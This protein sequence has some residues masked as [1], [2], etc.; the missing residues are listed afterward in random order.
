[1]TL[2]TLGSSLSADSDIKA[3]LLKNDAFVYAHLVKIEKA[4]K[5]ITGDNSRK[6]SDYAY[7]TD[8]GFDIDFDDGSTDGSGAA[9]GSR[10]F[11]ANKLIST[12]SISETIEARASSISIQLSAAAL[13]TETNIDFTTTSSSIITDVD[14]VDAGFA[15]GDKIQL[16]VTGAGNATTHSGNY[17]T[18][19]SFTNNNKTAVID[20][21]LLASASDLTAI[22]TEREGKI[23]FSS[24]EVIGLLNPKENNTTYAGYIN[25]DVKIYKAHIQPDTGIIIGSPYLLFKGIIA[26][27]KIVENPLKSSV[28][29]WVINSHWG[30]FVNVNGRL[31]SD[32]HHRA[33][34]GSGIPDISAL[35]RK[36]YADDLGFLHSEQAINLVSIYQ[37]KETKTRLEKKK[38]FF[39]L[40]KKY[41]Q[42]EYEVEVDREVDLRFNLD[43]KHLPVVYGV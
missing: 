29:T 14:L 13:N 16:T 42:V 26:S 23:T 33:L 4:V 43:A 32:Q 36:E 12:G 18:I 21:T 40:I 35:D 30:D 34:D 38:K 27:S 20:T 7:I 3:S 6:A 10:T 15:E 8:S 37:A 9:N 19:K 39:G 17:Y 28:I 5:T 1:M 24:E 25:R 22:S 41:N 2:R 31:T 11:F